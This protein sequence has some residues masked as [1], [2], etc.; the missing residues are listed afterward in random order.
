MPIAATAA[1]ERNQK[2]KV[3]LCALHEN[4]MQRNLFNIQCMLLLSISNR[5]QHRQF[6]T[7]RVR[8][9]TTEHSG[10]AYLFSK[11]GKSK[12]HWTIAKQFFISSAG[13][14]G[15]TLS[16]TNV[17]IDP[18]GYSLMTIALKIHCVYCSFQ[19]NT[20]KINSTRFTYPFN[21]H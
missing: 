1:S 21:L 14:A 12:L 16:L 19:S 4:L 10:T 2:F 3:V 7:W 17:N 6:W 18:L 20:I 15:S 11:E 8:F 13:N 5:S 9:H